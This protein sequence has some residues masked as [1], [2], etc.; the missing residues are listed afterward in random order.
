VLTDSSFHSCK[1]FDG[2][3]L[4]GALRPLADLIHVSAPLRTALGRE[5][6]GFMIGLMPKRTLVVG[7]LLVAVLLLTACA[8]GPNVIAKTPT[9]D[10]N[11]AGF[12]LGLWHGLICPISFFISLFT[13]SVSF[14]EVH[15]NGGWYNFGFLLGAAILLGGGGSQTTSDSDS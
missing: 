9:S 15:N 1:V 14:Y 2:P 12:W 8:P 6:K 10:G 11:V 5:Y 7:L 4:H 3:P 13:D